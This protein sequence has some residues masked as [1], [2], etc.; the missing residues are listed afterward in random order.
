ME[1]RYWVMSAIAEDGH[2]EPFAQDNAA[3]VDEEAGGIILYGTW[4]TCI[5]VVDALQR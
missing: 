5:K 4:E 2:P 1:P 3:V